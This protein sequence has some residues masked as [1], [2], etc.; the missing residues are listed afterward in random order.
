M[1]RVPVDQVYLLGVHVVQGLLVDAVAVH[2]FVVWLVY[3]PLF[4]D[5]W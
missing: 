1:L 4:P 3:V 5:E 2:V